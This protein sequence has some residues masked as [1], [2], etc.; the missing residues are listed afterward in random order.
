MI[1]KFSVENYKNFKDSITLDFSKVRDYDFNTHLIKEGVVNKCLIY[2]PNSSGKSNFGFAIMDITRHLTDQ[3]TVHGSQFSKNLESAKKEINFEYVFLFGKQEITYKYTKDDNL[4]LLS[5]EIIQDGKT[6]FFYDYRTKE[7]TNDI[8]EIKSVI[9]NNNSEGISVLKYIR[10]NFLNF[11]D[12][13]PVKLIVD[14][15]NS[16]LWFR[17]L[18]VN[19]FMTANTSTEDITHFIINN[20]F[21]DDFNNFLRKYNVNEQTVLAYDSNGNKYLASV[22]GNKIPHFFGVI[23]TGT[24]ALTLL[25]YWKKKRFDNIKFLFIDEFDAFYHTKV[26]SV[27]LKEINKL[28]HIQTILT[29]H[30][31]YLADNS[32]M[33]PDCYFILN[34]N[35]IKSFADRTNK[36]IREG[37]NISKMMLADEFE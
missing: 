35:E 14:Y 16:M 27:I 5:E 25:Y 20:N 24:A 9:L 19:E 18:R 15:A 26:S 36:V 12:N 1:K 28:S 4:M 23:S 7:F 13:N 10:N 8:E 29:T 30:N 32:V 21:I 31:A 33:R 3:K 11:S 22:K 2:G 6:V 17:S 37:N 34:N